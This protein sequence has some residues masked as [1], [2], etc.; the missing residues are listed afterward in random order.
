MSSVDENW[1][2]QIS[3]LLVCLGVNKHTQAYHYLTS[4]LKMMKHGA[5]PGPE[6]WLALGV[7]YERRA[8]TVRHVCS[9]CIRTVYEK[10]PENF[11]KVLDEL[12]FTPPRLKDFL[13]FADKWL[14]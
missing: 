10:D 4:A 8:E 11:C 2:E 14:H 1:D 12:Y 6:M 5:R 9:S 13:V 7:C 3:S